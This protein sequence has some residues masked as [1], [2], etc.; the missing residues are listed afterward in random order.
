MGAKKVAMHANF[1]LMAGS[2][3]LFNSGL[4]ICGELVTRLCVS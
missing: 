2:N 1:A 3:Q 4:Q